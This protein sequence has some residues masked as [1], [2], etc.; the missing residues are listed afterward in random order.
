M[1]TAD[2]PMFAFPIRR[3]DEC[4]LARAN[5]YFH[6]AHPSLLFK[7]RFCR[8]PAPVSRH[9]ERDTHAAGRP[10]SWLTLATHNRYASEHHAQIASEIRTGGASMTPRKLADPLGLDS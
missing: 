7:E 6:P 5:Q 1:G 9:F 10:T 8:G 3:Q 4:A 2:V